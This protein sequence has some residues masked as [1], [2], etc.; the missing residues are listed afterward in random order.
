MLIL[1][2][3][4][5]LNQQGYSYRKI[6]EIYAKAP[7]TIKNVLDRLIN[8]GN[9]AYRHGGGRERITSVRD[10]N[11]IVLAVRRNRTLNSSQVRALVGIGASTTTIR[12][13]LHE[14]NLRA[15]RR[16]ACPLLKQAHR[17]ARRNWANN[18]MHWGVP[19]WQRCLFADE[20]RFTLY[21]NDGRL[22]VW[23]ETGERYREECMEVREA[24]GG[25]GVTIWGGINRNGRTDLV[26]LMRESMNAERYRDLCVRDI[27]IPYANNFGN[28][29]ILV[30]DNAR[31]HRARIVTEFIR[32]NN[33]E[34]MEWPAKS[35]DMNPIEHVWSRMKL[36]LNKRQNGFDDLNELVNAIRQEWEDTPQNFIRVLIDSMP[37]RV[38][39]VIRNRGGPTKY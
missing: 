7:S 20:S 25:G 6:A 12:R 35:P 29:F 1:E 11:R 23:R 2:V 34:R 26:V 19:E 9:S 39:D 24:F 36:K 4:F 33:I 37:R 15:R 22:L 17:A 27:V 13:R 31:P 8:T 14:R 28:D 18:H 5:R 3:Y 38:A 16:A 10:D 21:R 30:D 32:E